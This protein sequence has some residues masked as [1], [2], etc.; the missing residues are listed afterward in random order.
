MEI[1]IFNSLGDG[2]GPSVV[3]AYIDEV[4]RL[5]AEGFTTLWSA[6]LP[7][8][9]DLLAMQALALREVPGISLAVGVLPIQVAHPM[10]TAQRALTLSALSG[11]R[12]KLGLGVNHPQMSEEYWGVQWDK[13][14]RRM[15]EYLD[16]LQP[17]LAGEAAHAIGETVTTRGS[18]QVSGIPE[19]PVYIAAL[20]PQMLRVA[21]RRTAGTFTWMTGPKT[22]ATH[23]VPT[24]QDEAAA[25]GRPKGAVKVVAGLPV[26]VTDGAQSA[27]A[28]AAEQFAIYGTLP[29]YRAMLDR[30]GVTGPEEL[31]LIGDEATVADRIDEIRSAG[32]DEFAGY[33]FGDDESRART[34]AVLRKVAV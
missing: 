24:L 1:S 14:I 9:I 23:V 32:V 25:A 11:G 8:E 7:W 13:P 4:S 29:S 28:Q 27:R 22:L 31:A 18:L 20:G 19:P 6:Q 3:A 33:L 2:D 10:L 17:L 5:A 34:R 30:E 21:A 26:C 15:N 16:G 12:F